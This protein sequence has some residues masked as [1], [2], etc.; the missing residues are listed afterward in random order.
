MNNSRNAGSRNARS[1]FSAVQLRDQPELKQIAEI[2]ACPLRRTRPYSAVPWS[3]RLAVSFVMGKFRLLV[4]KRRG[5]T[6]EKPP[7]P[8]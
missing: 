6:S 7:I 4:R 8:Y 5:I 3:A 1:P 2:P